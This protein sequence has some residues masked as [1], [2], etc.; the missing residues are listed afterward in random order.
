MLKQFNVNKASPML[1]IAL[2]TLIWAGGYGQIS[3]AANLST[4]V[5]VEVDAEQAGDCSE[6]CVD[7]TLVSH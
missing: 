6:N 7:A 2:S 4:G 1:V 3:A 5:A